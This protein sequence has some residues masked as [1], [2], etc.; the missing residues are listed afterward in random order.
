MLKR[1]LK[2]D[3]IKKRLWHR[4]FPVNF[5]K[6][7][8]TPFL[9]EHLRSLLLKCD[10]LELAK[11]KRGHF[12][13]RLFCS[14]GILSRFLFYLNVYCIEYTFRIYIPLHIKKH[15]FIHFSCLFLKSFKALTLRFED[16]LQQSMRQNRNMRTNFSASAIPRFQESIIVMISEI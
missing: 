7:L 14:K 6:F 2:R 9:T 3:F 15:Y 16:A 13:Y 8:R 1:L 12:L 11:E 5:V 10:A 4:C